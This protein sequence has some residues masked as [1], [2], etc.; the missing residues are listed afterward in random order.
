MKLFYYILFF[1]INSKSFS[2]NEK[3]IKGKILEFYNFGIIK[4]TNSSNFE[5]VI[6]DEK[7]FFSIKAMPNDMLLFSSNDFDYTPVTI[8]KKDYDMK[9]LEVKLIPKVILL[10]EVIVSKSPGINALKLGILSKPIKKYTVQERKYF[11]AISNPILSIINHIN[12]NVK[13]LKKNIETESK[14]KVFDELTDLINDD[15][16]VNTLEISKD[17]INAFKYFLIEDT[18]FKL[19]YNSKKVDEVKFVMIDL[20]TKFKENNKFTK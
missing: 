18:I 4:I 6:A 8:Y 9:L 3:I 7:G 11:S 5:T 14:I 16:Y 19:H 1:L 2:Q 20:S 10:K 15:F 17:K 12:G 13:T